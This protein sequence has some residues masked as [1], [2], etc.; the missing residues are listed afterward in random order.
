[1]KIDNKMAFLNI[2]SLAPL[3]VLVSVLLL[4][5]CDDGGS[6]S[7]GGDA[8]D[9][10]I[11]A[12]QD[13]VDGVT[14]SKVDESAPEAQ[15]LDLTS[16]EPEDAPA[17][18][19]APAKAATAPAQKTAQASTRSNQSARDDFDLTFKQT[20]LPCGEC[21]I[22]FDSV[23]LVIVHSQG[24]FSA[25]RGAMHIKKA[26]YRVG[27]FKADISS[28]PR[29]AQIVRATL[30]MLFNRDE[31]IA[32]GDHGT[33]ISVYD[34]RSSLVRK[35]TASGDIKGKGYSKANPLLPVD[36][37]AYAKRL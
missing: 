17:P 28:I 8:L 9:T 19:P 31:G 23:E 25:R 4:S 3:A 35:I 15:T 1:M 7:S 5:G 30:N 10:L 37:T 13:S 33:V 2:R 21:G 14:E 36:F 27:H 18:A 32:N 11:T 24:T 6:S 22:S 29:E 16:T 26:P 20:T 12:N 34:A